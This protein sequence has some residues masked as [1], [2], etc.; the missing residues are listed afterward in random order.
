MTVA[1][2]GAIGACWLLCGL[3]FGAAGTGVVGLR[4]GMGLGL[5][6][7][8]GRGGCCY[9]GGVLSAVATDGDVGGWVGGLVAEAVQDIAFPASVG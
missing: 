6:L 2:D 9:V 1:V 5:G 7:G 3:R 4:S 8:V